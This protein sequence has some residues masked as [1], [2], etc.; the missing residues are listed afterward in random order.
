MEKSETGI[1]NVLTIGIACCT[2][3]MSLLAVFLNM[4]A[5]D[6]SKEQRTILT[7]KNINID[8]KNG[9]TINWKNAEP[10]TVVEREIVIS[11]SE[12]STSITKYRIN[13]EVLENNIAAEY[14]VYEMIGSSSLPEDESGE[15]FNA[16]ETNYPTDGSVVYMDGSLKPGETHTY[17][18][19]LK[20]RRISTVKKNKFE[21]YLNVEMIEPSDGSGTDGGASEG[22]ASE[23]GST[24]S[25]GA[26]A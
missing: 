15:V 10:G 13:L 16:E 18:Y 14:L 8:F 26:Q 23:G 7:E 9:N 24:S 25:G 1:I 4:Y 22:G 12:T 21:S 19:Y 2:V 3:V 20:Y 6:L 11:A 17:K 5:Y